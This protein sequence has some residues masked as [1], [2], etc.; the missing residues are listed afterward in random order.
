MVLVAD[1]HRT[2]CVWVLLASALSACSPQRPIV[3]SA[4]RMPAQ[5]LDRAETGTQIATLPRPSSGVVRLSLF[6][7]AGSRDAS[8]PQTATLAAWVAAANG[9]MNVEATVYPDVTE[10]ALDCSTDALARC[11][12]QLAHALATRDPPA[13]SLIR[14][15]QRLHDSQR[16]AIEREP[17]QALDQRALSGLLGEERA[18]G[19]FP[20]GQPTEDPTSA[21]ERVPA[22]LRDHYGPGRSQLVAA[23]DVDPANVR[24][25]VSDSFGRSP[26]AL[27]PRAAR[28]LAL[29]GE[30][31]VEVSFDARGALS[32]AIAGR[33]EAT[34]RAIV[35]DVAPL[36]NRAEPRVELS[37]SI[38]AARGGAIAL[39]HAQATDS[40]LALD[41]VVRELTRLKREPSSSSV[42]PVAPDDLV[43]SSRRFGLDF[44]AGVDSR[45]GA[46]AAISGEAHAADVTSAP[47]PANA[48]AD[49]GGRAEPPFQF[50]AALQ[51]E[52]GFD[53]GPH[54]RDADAKAQRARAEHAKSAFMRAIGE[55]DA[56]KTHGDLDQYGA[57]V[58]SA[59]GARIDV[60]VAQSDD[61]AIAVRIALGS[62]RDPALLH[63]QAAMLATLT[64]VACAGM[65]PELLHDQLVRL[66]ASLE[67]RVDPESYGLLMRVP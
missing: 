21:A 45:A 8:P 42:S 24:A 60:Q 58:V 26:R 30:P 20:I 3:K 49:G 34:L 48:A 6:I 2:R 15:R 22:F 52:A 67:P 54:G 51:L 23:G 33:D 62:E 41:R 39:L 32:I 9:G 27:S 10:L 36:S 13:A 11:V 17:L 40:E 28:A 5:V 56:I 19:F 18:R 50:S 57:S 47:A 59:N 29:A 43:A 46:A 1:V 55:S 16:R 7:D 66:G 37:G 35:A 4:A 44:G 65:G 61:V 25:A 53:G 64:S 14:A 63:G 12:E 38:F 31:R